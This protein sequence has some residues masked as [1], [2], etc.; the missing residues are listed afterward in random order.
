MRR[1]RKSNKG[2]IITIIFLLVICAVALYMFY[3]KT[4]G[5]TQRMSLDKYFDMSKYNENSIPLIA[6]VELLEN[7]AYDF[8]GEIYV[9]Q[10][11]LASK[12]DSKVY[13][14][15]M[16]KAIILTTPTEIVTIPAEKNVMYVNGVET[17]LDKTVVKVVDGDKY[18]VSLEF[19]KN[20]I[21]I[22]YEVYENP[23]RVVM[24]CA[25]GEMFDKVKVTLQTM[26]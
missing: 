17:A 23:N 8:D 26:M 10:S 16:N 14:D 9:E 11:V 2:F 4:R 21:N 1:R 12:V 7:V 25:F 15:A 24:K 5:N 22:D 6:D 20:Y 3:I 19:L 18:V 13:L